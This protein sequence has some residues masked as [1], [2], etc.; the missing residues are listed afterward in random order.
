MADRVSLANK[1][2]RAKLMKIPVA[3]ATVNEAPPLGANFNLA[4]QVEMCRTDVT[5]TPFLQ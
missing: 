3:R 5:G 2:D 4:L 1:V